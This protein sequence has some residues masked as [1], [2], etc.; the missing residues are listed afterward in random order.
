MKEDPLKIMPWFTIFFTLRSKFPQDALCLEVYSA[1]TIPMANSVS[2][3]KFFTLYKIPENTLNSWTKVRLYFKQRQSLLCQASTPLHSQTVINIL[4]SILQLR[5]G[6]VVFAAEK[7]K[8]LWSHLFP[9]QGLGLGWFFPY[10]SLSVRED[11]VLLTW[12]ARFW[13]HSKS[14]RNLLLM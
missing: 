9:D 4:S 8:C 7:E 13:G 11:F 3:Y 10:H 2:V 6:V 1:D 14:Q 5:A 12:V